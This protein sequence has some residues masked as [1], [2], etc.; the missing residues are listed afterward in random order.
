MSCAFGFLV[1]TTLT[2][3]IYPPTLSDT[4]TRQKAL[5]C[6]SVF[7]RK[8]NLYVKLKKST[9]LHTTAVR[10]ASGKLAFAR[11]QDFTLS[12]LQRWGVTRGVSAHLG[13]SRPASRPGGPS[14]PQLAP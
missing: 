8:I 7:F 13:Q 9:F 5:P 14:P 11:F 2:P 1:R 6:E 12:H 10:V 3:I 4:A